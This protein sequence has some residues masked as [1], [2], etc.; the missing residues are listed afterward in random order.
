MSSSDS[1]PPAYFLTFN[2]YGTWLHGDKRTSVDRFH[3][4]YKTSR[5]PPK[6]SRLARVKK[7]M[8]YPAY[9]LDRPR[10]WATLEGI[11]RVAQ[12]AGWTLHAA[13]VRTEHVHVIVSAEEG[14]D[15]MIIR[16]K[17]AASKQMNSRNLDRGRRKRWATGGS[18]PGLWRPEQFWSALIYVIFEQG[19]PMALYVDPNLNLKIEGEQNPFG[20]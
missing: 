7:G 5:L 6:R 4:A 10:R 18:T 12:E 9:F 2:C 1:K 14:P 8:R 15:S 20:A 11:V 17:A 3:N 13:H 16:F 19:R